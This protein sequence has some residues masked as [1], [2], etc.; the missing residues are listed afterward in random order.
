M[1]RAI[2]GEGRDAV[3]Q[4]ARHRLFV[5]GKDSSGFDVR[6]LELDRGNWR[7]RVRAKPIW[8]PIANQCFR[9]SGRKGQKVRGL[10]KAQEVA[11]ALV[12]LPMDKQPDDFRKLYKL[13]MA[14]VHS[15]PAPAKGG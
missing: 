13:I 3:R 12:R 15:E 9:V 6:V 4:G 8:R 2:M 5:E 10:E 11:L 7:D 14:R 1:T